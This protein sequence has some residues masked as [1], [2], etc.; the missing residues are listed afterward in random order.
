[1]AEESITMEGHHIHLKDLFHKE[2]NVSHRRDDYLSAEH[3]DKIWRDEVKC[4][5]D[6]ELYRRPSS[7]K[8]VIS[9][10]DVLRL[11]PSSVFTNPTSEDLKSSPSS[12]FN[13]PT[14]EDL[15]STDTL[16]SS[17]YYTPAS[18]SDMCIRWREKIVEWMYLVID[19]FGKFSYHMSLLYP[20]L[21]LLYPVFI[22]PI[23]SLQCQF[24]IT[25]L[26][27]EIVSISAFYLDQYL[28]K[29]YVDEE[30]RHILCADVP[31]ED[32]H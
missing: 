31:S 27:R 17:D 9:D 26:S 7:P 24:T 15:K 5:H 1:M 32:T 22:Y 11:S 16:S 29:H 3:Q 8:D 14:S 6:K 21:Q 30:V 25:D 18:P 2:C 4:Q 10:R 13:N 23:P 12:V 28:S 20:P 19:R